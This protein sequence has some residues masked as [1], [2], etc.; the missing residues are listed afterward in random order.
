[1]GKYVATKAIIMAAG[2]GSRLQPITDETPKPLIEVNGKKMI[3]T[4]LDGLIQNGIKEIYIV[5]GYLKEKFSYLPEKYHPIKLTLLEN[6]HFETCNNISSLYVARAH[7]G[8]CI[9]TDGDLM[10]HNPKILNPNFEASGYC[11]TWADVTDEWL[12]TIDESNFVLSCSRTGGKN[13]WQ[14]FSI[15]FWSEEDGMKLKKHL[16][17]LVENRKETT[18]YWDD[19]AMFYY[20]DEYRLK[21][22]KINS[23]DV[24]EIDN[25]HELVEIDRSY[26]EI[27][28]IK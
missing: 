8:N 21:I 3:E 26:E 28:G 16:E 9:I 10:I 24:V 6:P 1:M 19:I 15:S 14:L 22:R 13:G 17:E 20:K 5:T 4:V 7:L 11:S 25:F 27:R 2:I 12:Q 18:L 23:D